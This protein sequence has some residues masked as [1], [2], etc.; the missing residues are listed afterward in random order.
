MLQKCCTIRNLFIY[1]REKC[2]FSLFHEYQSKMLDVFGFFSTS[3]NIIKKMLY[4][5]MV[6][7]Q[8]SSIFYF[9][10]ETFSKNFSQKCKFLSFF[11]KQISFFFNFPEIYF[12]LKIILKLLIFLYYKEFKNSTFHFGQKY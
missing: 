9:F 2:S 4:F 5:N 1:L 10:S 7:R 3:L 6:Y 11:I 12:I 8:N